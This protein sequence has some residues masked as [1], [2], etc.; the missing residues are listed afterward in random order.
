MSKP[1]VI[2]ATPCFGGLLSQAYMLSIMRMMTSFGDQI[3]LSLMLLGNDALITRSRATLVGKFLDDHRASH[4]LFID[5][6]IAFDP[7]Q[8]V[9]LFRAD[10]DFAAAMYPIKEFD[11]NRLP[12]RHAKGESFLNAGLNYVGTLCT[13]SDLKVESDFATARYAGA[14]FQL[15]KRCV[16]ERMIA[17]YPELKYSKIHA[18]TTEAPSKDNLYALFDPF[19][20]KE[21]GEYLSEDYAFCKRY[22]DIGGEIWLDLKSKLTHVGANDYCGDSSMRFQDYCPSAMDNRLSVS[23]N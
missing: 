18:Q 1:Y 16:L 11:W 12:L 3:D 4:L 17:A 22:R 6:D 15:I 20:D 9:R 8:F 10:K 5:S 21:T 14:G 7:E 19:V 2:I 23:P 13:G